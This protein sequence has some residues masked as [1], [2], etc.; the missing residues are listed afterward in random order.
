MTIRAVRLTDRAGD[1]ASERLL[2]MRD[3]R[4]NPGKAATGFFC[5]VREYK[6]I[7]SYVPQHIGEGHHPARAWVHLLAGDKRRELCIKHVPHKKR[8]Q[9]KPGARCTRSLACESTSFVLSPVTG[10]SCH[11][12]PQEAFASREL[13]ASVGSSGP[14]DFAVRLRHHSSV[15]VTTSIASRSQR[16]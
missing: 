11:R 5:I 1:F 15:G 8:A 2:Q 14:P 12:H 3:G 9:G 6:E 13:D 16:S 10:L 7:R 4:M